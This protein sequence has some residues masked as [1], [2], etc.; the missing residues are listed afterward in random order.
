MTVHRYISALAVHMISLQALTGHKFM[1]VGANCEARKQVLFEQTGDTCTTTKLLP[2]NMAAF[3]CNSRYSAGPSKQRF[4]VT[5]III[6]S[7]CIDQLCLACWMPHPFVL[8]PGVLGPDPK[9]GLV[10]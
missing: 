1:L 6:H 5:L 9:F 3:A 7:C 2:I 4:A 8:W 10:S